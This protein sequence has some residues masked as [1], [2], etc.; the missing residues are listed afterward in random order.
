[1][2]R[3]SIVF[4]MLIGFASALWAAHS[5]APVYD[6]I[7]SLLQAPEPDIATADWLTLN[8]HRIVLHENSFGLPGARAMVYTPASPQR[9]FDVVTGYARYM[10]FMPEIVSLEVK[11]D[12]GN[13]SRVAAE[14]KTQWPF[15]NL[16]LESINIKD[17]AAYRMAWKAVRTNLRTAQGA[18]IIKPYKQG[19]LIIYQM[20]F[21]MNWV[22]N[23]LARTS[24]RKRVETILRAVVA[25]A[26]A[27]I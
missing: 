8:E 10:D 23:V 9:V 3:L 7:A 27:Q 21:D 5:P 24:G 11:Q 18:W 16:Q 22:P 14:Y 26:E 17:P 4:V 19:S 12:A 13:E 6:D 20:G 25:R 1:M 2:R 15:A